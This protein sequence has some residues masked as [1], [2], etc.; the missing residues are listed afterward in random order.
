MRHC[1]RMERESL[2]SGPFRASDLSRPGASTRIRG[3]AQVTRL[4]HGVYIASCVPV[5][6]EVMA[7]AALLVA[8]E[9]TV[10][11]RHT[12]ARL[13]GGI[14]PDSS[15]VHLSLLAG[16][17]L[18]IDGIDARV[19]AGPESTARRGLPLTT[20]VQ[21]FVDLAN[22]LDLVDLVVLGDSLVRRGALGTGQLVEAARCHRGRG[23]R[24]ARRAA[25]L[26][27]DR[28]DSPMETRLRL[29]IVLAG[30]PEPVINVTFRSEQGEWRFRL[31]LAY[32]QWKVAIEYDG[33]PPARRVD[34][35][36]DVGPAASRVVRR[37]GLALSR[38][39]L[40]RPV[41]RAVRRAQPRRRGGSRPGRAGRRP[42]LGVAPALPRPGG[43]VTGTGQRICRSVI[44]ATDVHQT[45]SVCVRKCHL[46]HGP[47]AAALSPRAQGSPTGRLGSVLGR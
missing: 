25:A 3:G 13:W 6:P 44:S 33:R 9:G 32:P 17:R 8:P 42:Q 14:V 46:G 31:D 43:G 40:E 30:L 26:V 16:R 1:R 35:A 7:R 23:A 11:A 20:P 10:L 12:A 37:S 2:P 15:D 27:R 24:S 47:L 38:S 45:Q 22:D 41:S 21:T 29:L 5:T 34:E 4:F 19:C 28:V 18:R 39:G 36:V